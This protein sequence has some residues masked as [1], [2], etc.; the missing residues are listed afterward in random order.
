MNSGINRR[1]FL[2]QSAGGA[3]ALP[4]LTSLLAKTADSL[5]T[6][7]ATRGAGVGAKRFVAV[8]NLL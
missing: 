6:I 8:G 2:L 4:G 5:A 7:Q 1:R 3:L